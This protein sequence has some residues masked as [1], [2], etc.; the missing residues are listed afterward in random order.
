MNN[1]DYSNQVFI[2]CQQLFHEAIE[3]GLEFIK[4]QSHRAYHEINPQRIACCANSRYL[5]RGFYCPSPVFDKVLVNSRRGKILP[6]CRKTIQLTHRYFY[7]QDDKIYLIEY[8]SNGATE[9]Y[10]YIVERQNKRF[11]FIIDDFGVLRHISIE[12]YNQGKLI[13]YMHSRCYLSTDNIYQSLNMHHEQYYYDPQQKLTNFD[14]NLIFLDEEE[15]KKLG[16]AISLIDHY[17]YRVV[18]E[19][20]QIIGVT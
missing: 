16:N 20:N 18:Y 17:N 9:A 4:K 3:Y 15:Y 6:N 2:S 5:H 7:N 11:G 14:L 8:F 10:E 19:G 13:A 12:E 1:T